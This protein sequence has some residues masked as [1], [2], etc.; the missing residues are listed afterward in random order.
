[1]RRAFE[2]HFDTAPEATATVVTGQ[3]RMNVIV[4][5]AGMEFAE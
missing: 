2:T 4:V 1:M 5:N 3:A